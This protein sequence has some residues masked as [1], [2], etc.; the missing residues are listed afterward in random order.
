MLQTVLYGGAGESSGDVLAT[1]GT[2]MSQNPVLYVDPVDGNDANDGLEPTSAK[3]TLSG[4]F[5]ACAG[6]EIIFILP[7]G[8]ATLTGAL[9]LNVA[10]TIV[11][12]GALGERPAATVGFNGVGSRIIVSQNVNFRNLRFLTREDAEVNGR[13]DVRVALATFAGCWFEDDGTSSEANGALTISEAT[14]VAVIRNCTFESTAAAGLMPYAGLEMEEGNIVYLENVTF[15][16]GETGYSEGALVADNGTLIAEGIDLDTRGLATLGGSLEGWVHVLTDAGAGS[17]TWDQLVL[18]HYAPGIGVSTGQLLATTGR[19]TTRGKVYWVDSETG[20]D[21]YD[22]RQKRRPFATLSAALAVAAS[23]DIIALRSTHDETLTTALAITGFT[24]L[25]IIGEG[26]DEDGEPTAVLRFDGDGAQLAISAGTGLQL[27]NIRFAPNTQANTVSRIA[28]VS[29]A[30]G[31]QMKNCVVE[32]DEF[33]TVPGLDIDGENVAN[34]YRFDTV[35]FRAVGT[36]PA[37]APHSGA[38][39]DDVVNCHMENVTLDGG[40][41]GFESHALLL[42]EMVTSWAVN[43]RLLNGADIAFTDIAATGGNWIHFAENSESTYVDT[44][45]IVA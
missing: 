41:T 14:S 3:L 17:V 43:T 13:V 15:R 36:D 5:A 10:V 33:D 6:G 19:L 34:Y 42:N 32:C 18:R 8:A 27:R 22:G 30:N 28:V 26:L 4:A 1:S 16:G 45:V 2:L 25:T 7:T 21:T 44:E 24:H 40:E 37:V 35:T 11:G 12:G 29:T 31:F 23:Y 38:A 39:F 9:T 20:D